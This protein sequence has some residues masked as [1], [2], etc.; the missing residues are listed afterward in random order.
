MIVPPSF[1]FASENNGGEERMH[2]RLFVWVGAHGLVLVFPEDG[3]SKRA[4]QR[5]PHGEKAGNRPVCVVNTRRNG[6]GRGYS[7]VV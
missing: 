1:S 5:K 3:E 6:N 2:E 7:Q 4:V